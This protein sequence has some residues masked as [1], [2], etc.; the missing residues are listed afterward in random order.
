MKR[1]FMAITAL[2]L[3]ASCS[4]KNEKSDA[5]GNFEAIETIISSEGNGKITYLNVEEGQELRTGDTAA[6]IDT[7]QT[8]LQIA[9]LRSRK[10]AVTSRSPGV[11]AQIDVLR[12]EKRV[13]EKELDR[14][15]AMLGGN[16]ATKKQFDDAKGRIDVLDK[17]IKS[18]ESQNSPI[19]KE[20][21]SIEAQIV[22]MRDVLKKCT[23]IN[24]VEGVV[25]GKYAERYEMTAAGKP[26]YK[27]A[28]LKSLILRVY[29]SGAQ[30]PSLKIGGKV[31][32]FADKDEGTD[33]QYEGTVEWISSR[34]EFTPK[35]IQTKEERVKQ[36]YA[37]KIRVPNDGS[38]KIGM[39]GEV[40]F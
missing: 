3:L 22:Q 40:V 29:V 37:V 31:K 9:Q 19:V 16:A 26:L 36:V 11:F 17:Q 13:A 21:G 28:N 27:I 20:A 38:L 25:I 30:L 35:I 12:E 8:A 39:P 33:K 34:A 14:I 1:M 18:I 4:G 15:K 32:V 23:V 5:F 6:V 7:T 10:I 2:A 24:P